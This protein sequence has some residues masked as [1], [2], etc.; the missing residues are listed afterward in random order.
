MLCFRILV[1]NYS[2]TMVRL[3]AF[4]IKYYKMLVTFVF[5]GGQKMATF[6]FQNGDFDVFVLYISKETIIL[7]TF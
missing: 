4:E 3:T 1:S 6:Y 7:V 5:D 2:S